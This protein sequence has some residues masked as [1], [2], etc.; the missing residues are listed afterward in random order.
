MA[1][2]LYF[3]IGLRLTAT[4]AVPMRAGVVLAVSAGA[5]V[6]RV[7]PEP[8]PGTDTHIVFARNGLLPEGGPCE[9]L[10]GNSGLLGADWGTVLDTNE[11]QQ[12][13]LQV[14]SDDWGK[15]AAVGLVAEN[16]QVSIRVRMLRSKPL[17]AI[18]RVFRFRGRNYVVL[19]IQRPTKSRTVREFTVTGG[20]W[21]DLGGQQTIPVPDSL[22][23]WTG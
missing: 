22:T 14:E 18:G 12:V 15:V 10:V 16:S 4:V 20:R 8:V 17:P 6:A 19:G 13:D 23:G 11:G 7:A 3:A 9:L 5:E 1:E 21:E 2:F